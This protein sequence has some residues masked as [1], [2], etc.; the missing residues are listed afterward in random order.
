MEITSKRERGSTFPSFRW[1]GVRGRDRFVENLQ[2]Q[3]SP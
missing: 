2:G 3:A 1:E